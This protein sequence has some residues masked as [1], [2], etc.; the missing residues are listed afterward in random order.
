[1]NGAAHE[2]ASRGRRL[3]KP[4]DHEHTGLRRLFVGKIGASLLT[5]TLITVGCAPDMVEPDGFVRVPSA[6]DPATPAMD[7]APSSMPPSPST[8]N[9]DGAAATRSCDLNGHWLIAQRVLATAIG[10]QQAAHSWFYYEIEQTGANLVVTRGLHCGFAVVKKTSLAANVDSSG[11]WPM[12]L[13]KNSSTGRRGTY[14]KA[15]D[16]CRLMLDT[17]YVVRGATVAAYLDPKQ[18]LPTRTQKATGTTPGWEDWDG[19]DQ[20]GISL[21]V[22]S[23]LASGTLYTVQRD[24]TRYEGV[25]SGVGAKFKVAIGYGGEQVPLGRSMGAPQAIESGSSPSS[26]PAQH[27][28]WFA[29]LEES[30][31]TGSPEQICAAVR[32]LKDQLVPEAGQ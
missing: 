7:A 4:L 9:G 18:P 24:W 11:S 26:D 20:P 10:Q 30:E 17:E 8:S 29:R 28:A 22:S 1:M 5:A 16:G 3:A 12:F 13:Q 21:K 19:D 23:S 2:A 31:A 32:A 14:V 6:P 27:Y 15:G 25:T